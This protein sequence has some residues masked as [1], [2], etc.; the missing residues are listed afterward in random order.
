MNTF[1]SL[2]IFFILDDGWHRHFLLTRANGHRY[3]SPIIH[4]TSKQSEYF[5][6]QTRKNVKNACIHLI[7]K[8]NRTK[9][10]EIP[11][12]DMH[13]QTQERARLRSVNMNT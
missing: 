11:T 3:K 5:F 13:K 4:S 9:A 12:Y 8:L 6:L 10:L 1:C 2:W 7:Y